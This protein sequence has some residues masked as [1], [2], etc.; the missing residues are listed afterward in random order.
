MGETVVDE[1]TGICVVEDVAALLDPTLMDV[2]VLEEM[3]LADD[4]FRLVVVS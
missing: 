3:S 1:E 2:T 4:V